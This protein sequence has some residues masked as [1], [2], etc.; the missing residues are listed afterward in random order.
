MQNS[1]L[2]YNSLPALGEQPCAPR[3]RV[4]GLR[5]EAQQ[6]HGVHVLVLLAEVLVPARAPE[7]TASVC[8][9][10]AKKR[11]G[12]SKFMLATHSND[13]AT[14]SSMRLLRVSC[15]LAPRVVSKRALLRMDPR[16]QALGRVSLPS[17]CWK[18]IFSL[19]AAKPG[20]EWTE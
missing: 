1:N 10:G 16:A 5:A 14:Y 19:G 3:L 20:H 4:V 7:L 13:C 8:T 9:L 11:R 18:C 15:K 2:K 17:G 6:L 12:P